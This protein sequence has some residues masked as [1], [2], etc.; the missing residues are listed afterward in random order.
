MKR[1][2]TMKGFFKLGVLAG[3]M[4]LA[5]G[6]AMAVDYYLV[7]K[8]YDKPLPDGTSVPM[9]GYVEDTATTPCYRVT[10]TT[11][12]YE[13]YANNR[14]ARAA[15]VDLLPQPGV[16]NPRLVID[17]TDTQLRIFLTNGLDEHTSILIPG[18][19]LPWS[20]NNANVAGPVWND[21]SHGP[22]GTDATKRVRSFVAE[23][24][25]NGGIRAYV[26]NNGRGNPITRSGT[27][28]YHTGTY[29]Q[30]QLYMGLFGAVTKDFAPGEAYAGVTYD[31]E[32]VLTYSD[33]DTVLNNAIADGS[34]TTSIDHHPTWFM[35]NGESYATGATPD[36][37]IGAPGSTTLL[38]FLSAAGE[39]HV[40]TLQGLYMD[41]HA[42]DGFQYSYTE[43]GVE[44]AHPRTQYSIMMPALKTKDAT[45]VAPDGRFAVY[46]GNGHM[47]N[48][49]DINDITVG[50][51]VGGMLRF[52]A[53]TA[54]V[55]DADGDGIADDVDNCPLIANP[56]QSDVDADGIGDVCDP[57][58][59][60]DLDGDGV[61]NAADNCP[62]DANADQADLDGDGTGDVCDTDIDGDGILNGADN[63]PVDVNPDQSDV[64]G[65]GIGD[66]CDP[67]D[68]TDSDADGIPDVLD[69]CPLVSNADQ[70]DTDGNG[71]GDACEAGSNNLP[72][73][74]GD[75][76]SVDEDVVLSVPAPGVLGND[77]DLDGDSLTVLLDTD[78]SNGTLTLSPDGS[79]TYIPSADFN[80]SDSFTYVAND[81]TVSSGTVTVDITV[82]AVN[83]PPVA[84]SDV[85][86]MNN[87]VAFTVDAER[88]LTGTYTMGGLLDNDTDVDST[89]LTSVGATVADPRGEITAFNSDG[90]FTYFLN[91]NNG[92]VGD[93][94]SFTY[95]ANDSLENSAPATVSIVRN[96]TITR[97]DLIVRNASRSDWRI[98]TR[99]IT[100]FAG[101]TVTAYLNGTTLIGSGTFNN[102]NPARGNIN[103]NNTAVIPS[104][105]D[106]LTIV[107]TN[108]TAEVA[109]FSGYP[110][111]IVN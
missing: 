93:I 78:V 21:G 44:T 94:A 8:A 33:I 101:M 10:T 71:V 74:L 28:M 105:G 109:R 40:P 111:F 18:L 57:V 48:P 17:P 9:W 70:T 19:E 81:G 43:G 37:D 15:C 32:V 4:A 29:P 3:A 55:G 56:D 51:E 46:D 24:N 52:L 76:Y 99:G 12:G 64:D 85:V 23:A 96:A 38:R 49:S 82:N 1:Y 95:M 73:A 87:L 69:N 6:Q 92:R 80:G 2:K 47:T 20:S 54:V 35:V 100:D 79:F 72:T 30:K 88:V 65:D 5:S 102:Q 106:T 104:P 45:V 59:D 34:Y 53:T 7:A 103:D 77:T 22:R 11:A 90:T 89:T 39:T 31:N 83:D 58:N 50:D 62:A 68:D 27:F 41:I 91:N 42:E 61:L 36:I 66:V 25:P 26:W 107:V 60:L 108:G 67:L 84:V 75:A 98:R 14:L 16:E 86:E 97:A 63:C 110:V 13:S